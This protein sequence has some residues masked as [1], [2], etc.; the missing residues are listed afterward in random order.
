MSK[1]SLASAS[2]LFTMV[3]LLIALHLEHAYGKTSP[4]NFPTIN[5]Y[6]QFRS[7]DSSENSN[8]RTTALFGLAVAAKYNFNTGTFGGELSVKYDGTLQED[9]YILSLVEEARSQ[10][11][12]KVNLGFTSNTGEVAFSSEF[13]LKD[14][15]TRRDKYDAVMTADKYQT[16]AG[17]VVIN[18]QPYPVFSGSVSNERSVVD[19]KL[20]QSS[21]QILSAMLAADWASGPLRLSITKARME[22]RSDYTPNPPTSSEQTSV[23]FSGWFPLGANWSLANNFRYTEDVR[24]AYYAG[25]E[26]SK[27]MNTFGQLTFSGEN[28]THGLSAKAELRAEQKAFATPESNSTSLSQLVALTYKIPSDIL[29][30]NTLSYSYTNSDYEYADRDTNVRQYSIGWRFAPFNNSNVSATYKGQSST[31]SVAQSRNDERTNFD[32]RLSY[33]PGRFSMDSGYSYNL[34]EGSR[35]QESRTNEIYMQLGYKVF[36]PLSLSLRFNQWENRNIPANLFGTTNTS[37]K[38]EWQLSARWQP[39]SNITI[40][41]GFRWQT[42]DN[43]ASDRQHSESMQIKL[44]Y[45]ITDSIR[46]TVDFNSNEFARIGDPLS[47]SRN[48][49]L[50]TMLTVEF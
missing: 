28:L 48:T 35:G 44:N 5:T 39:V 20:S 9:E 15:Y 16:I 26:P 36:D 33:Q 38:Y 22:S 37:E 41:S 6:F 46:L 24:S 19:R 2:I 29:G 50:Q 18:K 40:D 49:V 17:T 23:N 45:A 7:E 42:Q 11:K 43:S 4:N 34:I 10:Q 25:Q 21:S 47:D 1:Q 27:S 13:S 31:D 8:D 14:V 12:Y 30:N 32:L 3:F